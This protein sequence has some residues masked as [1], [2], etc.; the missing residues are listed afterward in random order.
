MSEPT[1]GVALA[2]A[3]ATSAVMAIFGVSY[4]AL[5]WGGVGSFMGLVI[6][7]TTPILA[8]RFKWVPWPAVAFWLG[9][10]AI[11][12]VV[13]VTSALSG[14]MGAVLGE[15]LAELMGASDKGMRAL[16]AICAAGA[17]PI[18]GACVNSVVARVH[19]IGGIHPEVQTK[20]GA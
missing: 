15:A 10:L 6:T 4:Y 11:V 13:L 9:R 1:S 17:T 20:E 12:S 3:A 2:V 5:V 14:L 7:R 19:K 18:V 8:P 16:A